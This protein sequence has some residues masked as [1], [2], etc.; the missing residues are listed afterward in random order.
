[1]AGFANQRQIEL[2]VE[3]GFAVGEA[4][5]VVSAN[6]AKFLGIF[7]E[8]GTVTVGKRADLV[9]VKGDPEKRISD[10]RNVTLVFKAG[11][12]YD[13]TKIIESLKGRV[14]VQ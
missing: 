7:S 1:M 4:I 3:S 14:G 11:I 9:V 6:G 10:V 2:L 13:S 8:V 12:G 5:Q